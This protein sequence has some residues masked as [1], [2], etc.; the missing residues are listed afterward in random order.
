MQSIGLSTKQPAWKSMSLQRYM[1]SLPSE[2]I[3]TGMV[4]AQPPIAPEVPISRHETN[5]AP[6]YEAQESTMVIRRAKRPQTTSDMS[7]EIESNNCANQMDQFG[8]VTNIRMTTFADNPDFFKTNSLPCSP[9]IVPLPPTSTIPHNY[10]HYLRQMN[11]Q[12]PTYGQFPMPQLSSSPKP[13]VSIAP[14]QQ[15]QSSNGGIIATPQMNGFNS[16]P[17]YGWCHNGRD[18]VSQ[19]PSSSPSPALPPAMQPLPNQLPYLSRHWRSLFLL[20]L[21]VESLIW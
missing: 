9:K 8:R 10:S 16:Q 21:H 13:V 6:I 2:Q 20:N 14:T 5:F 12:E 4:Y 11:G 18:S 17:T 3:H 7:G 15:C 1:S 19:P